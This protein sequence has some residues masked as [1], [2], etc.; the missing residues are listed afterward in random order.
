M[1]INWT[2]RMRNEEVMIRVKEQSNILHKIKRWE[3]S[4]I[5]HILQGYFFKEI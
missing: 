3:G 4:S 1:E 5:V 2:D